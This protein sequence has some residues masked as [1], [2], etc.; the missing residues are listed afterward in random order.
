MVQHRFLYVYERSIRFALLILKNMNNFGNF[1]TM[2]NLEHPGGEPPA[3]SL[4]AHVITGNI[5]YVHFCVK[6]NYSTKPGTLDVHQLSAFDNSE[7]RAIRQM[8]TTNLN[9]LIMYNVISFYAKVIEN[10]YK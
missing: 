9:K 1:N 3:P 8:L 5:L 10:Q 4:G 6:I 2:P 7:A